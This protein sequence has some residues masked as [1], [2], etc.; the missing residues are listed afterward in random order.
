MTVAVMKDVD[1][2]WPVLFVAMSVVGFAAFAY[3][4]TTR[5]LTA[6]ES[7]FLQGFSVTIGFIGTFLFGRRS[8][9]D[10]AREVIKPHARS[11]F[12][13][14]VSLY[15]SL[16]R[17]TAIVE[18]RDPGAPEDCRVMLAQIQVIAVEQVSAADDALADWRDIVPE[19]VDE[20]YE[21]L[22]SEEHQ[23]A[24]HA[25]PDSR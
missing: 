12:R 21:K 5:T 6:L 24:S 23:E 2:A 18:S 8:A 15:Q 14:L 7:V 11:A 22:S 4:S 13:R 9:R 1:Y 3:V 10:A 16:H 17:M 20:L 19:D 25:R